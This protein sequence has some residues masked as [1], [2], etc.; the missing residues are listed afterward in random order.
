M[1]EGKTSGAHGH[2]SPAWLRLVGAMAAALT[3]AACAT[4]DFEAKP[5]VATV[6]VPLAAPRPTGLDTLATRQHQERFAG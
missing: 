4:S 3:L 6:T 2:P 5:A 1:V